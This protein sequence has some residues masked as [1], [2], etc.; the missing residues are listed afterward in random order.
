MCV[1]LFLTH[2]MNPACIPRMVT[3]INALYVD[4]GC[5]TD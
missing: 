3:T 4:I 5:K 1:D 2:S